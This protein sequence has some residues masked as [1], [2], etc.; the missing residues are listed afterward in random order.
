MN[1]KSDSFEQFEL[2]SAYLDGEVTQEER[3]FIEENPDLVKEVEKLKEIQKITSS[4]IPIDPLL[5][6]KHLAK[7]LS[8]LPEGG[9]V[10]GVNDLK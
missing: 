8:S 5:Q 7:A 4:P 3:A 1:K 6:E 2:I 9:K 10:R